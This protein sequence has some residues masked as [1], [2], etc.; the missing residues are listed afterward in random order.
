MLGPENWLWSTLGGNAEHRSQSSPLSCS[1]AQR[2]R[3]MAPNHSGKK[4]PKKS[5]IIYLLS[6]D[7]Q[8]S[9]EWP[10]KKCRQQNLLKFAYS[11]YSLFKTSGSGLCQNDVIG[12]LASN[13]KH[14]VPVHQ[15]RTSCTA[16]LPAHLLNLH[17]RPTLWASVWFTWSPKMLPLSYALRK[18]CGTE[19]KEML[20]S[21]SLFLLKSR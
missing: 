9:W 21:G 13:Y 16:P 19:R 15:I 20:R 8:S 2:H 6:L 14:T 17:H 5:P 3:L 10:I 12:C 4:K 18:V 7:K 1:S 11:A